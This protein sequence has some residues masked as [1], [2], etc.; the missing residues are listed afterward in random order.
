MTTETELTAQI[1]LSHVRAGD[2]ILMP[3]EDTRWTIE[4][5]WWVSGTESHALTITGLGTRHFKTSDAPDVTLYERPGFG[6]FDAVYKV[7]DR[8]WHWCNADKSERLGVVVEV[9]EYPGE[10]PP[11]YEMYNVPGGY[12]AV[13]CAWDMRRETTPAPAVGQTWHST[14]GHTLTVREVEHGGLVG[15][16]LISKPGTETRPFR[17]GFLLA[18]PHWHPVEA[19]TDGSADVDVWAPLAAQVAA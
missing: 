5:A 17:G 6:P 15:R 8:V 1:P 9:H 12:G 13:T 7:G 3:G 2:V 14:S 16:G 4:K 18:A 19:T 11:V 10:H